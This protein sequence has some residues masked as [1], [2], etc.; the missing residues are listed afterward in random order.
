MNLALK[1]EERKNAE[2]EEDME[3]GD[4]PE[5][6]LDPLMYT[7]M[8]DPVTLPTSKVNIDRATIKAHLLSDSTDPFN[9]M[10]L[11]LEQVIP[12]TELKQKIEE[13]KKNKKMKK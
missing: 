9:R 4:A 12:N 10:P 2:E 11:K 3:Y 5:E 1:A 13:Y 8:K 6:F 7:I